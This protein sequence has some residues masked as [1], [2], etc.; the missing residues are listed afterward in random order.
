MKLLLL[1]ERGGQRTVLARGEM[2]RYAAFDVHIASPR[3]GHGRCTGGDL[4][5]NGRREALRFGDA[6]HVAFVRLFERLEDICCPGCGKQ[7]FLSAWDAYQHL[8]NVDHVIGRACCGWVYVDHELKTWLHDD[9]WGHK[10]LPP[11]GRRGEWT[12]ARA[13]EYLKDGGAGWRQLRLPLAA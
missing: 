10:F 12:E 6:V 8:N 7:L 5:I 11:G 4:E 13:R 1:N 3:V 9:R 2:K